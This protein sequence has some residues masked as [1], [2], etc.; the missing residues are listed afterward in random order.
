[1][2]F[3]PATAGA[4]SGKIT[5]IG[6][7]LG[8]PQSISLSATAQDEAYIQASVAGVAF[9]VQ[10]IE[11]SSAAYAV[12]ITN[13]GTQAGPVSF[14][15][16]TTEF[17]ELNNC[18]AILAAHASCTVGVT[19]NPSQPGLETDSLLIKS[20][21][22]SSITIALSGTAKTPQASHAVTLSATALTF[23]PQTVGTAGVN[24][25]GVAITNTGSDPITLNSVTASGDFSIGFSQCYYP[26][27]LN[28]QES[29]SVTVTFAPT[30]SGTRA[31]TLSFSDSAAPVPQT[32]SLAGTA[33]ALNENL[34][35]Y[36][37]AAVVFPDQVVNTSGSLQTISVID[38]GSAA[39]AIDRVLAS[40]DY[41]IAGDSCSGQQ[42][43]GTTQDGALSKACSG[44]GGVH[45][46]G[47]R[48]AQ[49]YRHFH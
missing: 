15:L 34:E 18:P 2:Y 39:L 3:A 48:F 44:Q 35:F 41:K 20:T 32:V 10:T 16:G 45:A 6:S 37:S 23:T 8:S 31:G 17:S 49:R 46:H 7:Q 40:G 9:P 21:S 22:G 38:T 1:M 43:A 42:L 26:F 28:P 24:E 4:Y 11:T 36:P 5:I 14:S 19:F 12:T 30:T 33:L 27:P 47:R 25:E 13:A 29:C